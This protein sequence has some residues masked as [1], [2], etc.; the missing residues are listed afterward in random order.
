M[1]NMTFLYRT[2]F[3]IALRE[4]TAEVK[5]YDDEVEDW[6]LNDQFPACIHGTSL[7]TDYDNICG[8]C[9]ESYTIIQLAQG[10]ARARFR[11]YL[12]LNI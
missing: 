10:R 9:E 12:A 11:A 4:V 3:T 5:A 7:W 8:G 6:Y 2:L 1:D